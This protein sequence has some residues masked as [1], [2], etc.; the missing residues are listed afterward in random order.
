VMGPPRLPISA[1]SRLLPH[2]GDVT[3]IGAAA[4]ADE[5]EVRQEWLQRV[6]RLGELQRV[7]LVQLRSRVE[8]LMTTGRCVARRP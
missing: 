4:S 2:G 6:L 8:F 5:S 7:P 1:T 3:S